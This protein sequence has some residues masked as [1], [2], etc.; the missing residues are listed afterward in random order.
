[1][2]LPEAAFL[3]NF[4]LLAMARANK[5]PGG[6]L[7]QRQPSR[8]RE[9]TAEQYLGQSLRGPDMRCKV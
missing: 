2:V 6:A 1:M 7:L 3:S 9:D 8:Y 4:P 5:Q